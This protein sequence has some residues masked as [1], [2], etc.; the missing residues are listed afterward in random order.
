VTI[1]AILAIIGASMYFQKSIGDQLKAQGYSTTTRAVTPV[2]RP[3][4]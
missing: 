2:N 3:N 1:I 4:Q